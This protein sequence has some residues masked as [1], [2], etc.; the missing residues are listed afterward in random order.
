VVD[1]IRAYKVTEVQTCLLP[2]L[3]FPVRSHRASPVMPHHRGRTEAD[4]PPA[5]PEAPA[6]I[7]VVAGHTELRIESADRFEVDP[8][9]RHVA[10]RNVLRLAIGDEHVNRSAGRAGD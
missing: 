5:V 3:L 4:R 6:H 10:A 8:A 1:A 7:D 2:I 9:K